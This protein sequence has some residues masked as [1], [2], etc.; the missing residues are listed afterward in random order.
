MVFEATWLQI[1]CSVQS[2][3]LFLS[4]AGNQVVWRKDVGRMHTNDLD[5]T[6][7]VLT[8]EDAPPDYAEWAGFRKVLKMYGVL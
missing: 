8:I 7:I 1:R 3:G 6:H 5:T 2:V 4:A